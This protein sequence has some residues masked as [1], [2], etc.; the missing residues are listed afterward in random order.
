MAPG[1]QKNKR[2]FYSVS[3][4]SLRAVGAVAIVLVLGAGGYLA[5][6]AL[7]KGLVEREAAIVVEEAQR[8]RDQLSSQGGL[9]AFRAEFESAALVLAEA[10]DELAASDFP[11]ALAKGKRSQALLTAIEDALLH[12]GPGGEAQ[13]ISLKGGVQYRRG[14]AGEWGEARN[15]VVL[16]SG[17]YVKTADNGSAEIIFF[18]GTLFTVRP[19]T[20]VL[21][22]RTRAAGGRGSQGTIAL[23]YGWVNLSTS[24]R[25]SK[26]STPGAEAHVNR[27]TEAVV[28][29]DQGADSARFATHRGTL[30]VSSKSGDSRRVGP[31]QQVV[32]TGEELSESI[33]L[34]PTPVLLQPVDSLEVDMESVKELVLS[35]KKVDAA[36][37]YDLQVSRERLFVDNVIDVKKRK[38]TTATLGLRGE[39]TFLWRVAALGPSGVRGPWTAP[40]KFRVVSRRKGTAS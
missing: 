1:K 13:F 11:A 35:W 24:Q 17:D 39:G 4:D 5:Y 15:R 7:E 19:N 8:L 28:T 26:V 36:Q 10:S 29:Y 27:D 9:G 12:R 14:S 37:G 30:Q 22:N 25:D 34:P 23:E 31:L 2:Q 32:Q 16:R 18:D 21:V 38:K 6:R 20:V 3:A 40:Q 33:P